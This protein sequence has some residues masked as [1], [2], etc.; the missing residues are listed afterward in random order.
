MYP[1]HIAAQHGGTKG[2]AGLT[3]S[4]AWFDTEKPTYSGGPYQISG[5]VKDTSVT[6]VPNPKWYGAVKPSLD[7][8]IFQIITKQEE[9]IPALQNKEVQGIYPQ[10]NQDIVQQAKGISG[11]DTYLGKGL[12]WEH[13]DFNEKNPIL[14][15]VKLR[16]A[17]F[18]AIDR[19]QIITRTIGQFVNGAQPLNNHMYMPG[20]DGYADNVT[21]TGQGSGDVEKAKSIL[22][23]AGYTGIGS[24][25]KN[26]SGAAIT[27]RCSFT[28]GNLLRQQTCQV[29][30]TQLKQLGVTVKVTPIPS[31]GATLSTGDFDLILFAWVGAP[32]VFAGAQQTWLSTS[33]SNYG[34]NVNKEVDRLLNEA[35]ATPDPAL[36]KSNTDKA[37]KALTADAYVLPLFQKPTFLAVYSNMANVRDDATSTG[38]PYNVQ[39]WGLRAS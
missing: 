7:R 11:V 10:P 25:L 15:D 3:K 39:E 14:K 26:K 31:L 27:I 19:K 13:L 30:Q 18:T 38:P 17:L 20:Q 8:L 6:E 35:A 33:G 1:A 4:F 5:F 23:D 12:T 37:D 9:E 36:A 32:F 29:I 24:A 22:K 21:S 28:A 34:H 2:N 16:L